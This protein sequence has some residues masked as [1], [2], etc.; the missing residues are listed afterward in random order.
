MD[1]REDPVNRPAIAPAVV[2]TLVDSLAPRLRRRLELDPRLAESWSWTFTDGVWTVQADSATEVSLHADGVVSSKDQIRC[3]CLLA[4][5]CL[6]L[7][8]V[9]LAL[10]VQEV[11]PQVTVLDEGERVAPDDQVQLTPAQAEAVD[12]AVRVGAAMLRSGAAAFGLV[13]EAELLRTAHSCRIVGLH[14]LAAGLVRVVQRGRE[15]RDQRPEFR[16]EALAA[17]LHEVLSTALRLQRGPATVQLV[18]TARRAYRPAGSLQVAGIFTEAIVSAAGYA[19]VVT[20]LCDSTGRIWSIAD[21]APG[22]ADRCQVAY[23]SSVGVG[24]LRLSHAALSRAG[25]RLQGMTASADR[26]LGAGRDVRAVATGG[27]IWSDPPLAALWDE[28]LPRQ[29]DRV[30]ASFDLDVTERGAG[31]DLVYLAGAVVGV[32]GAALIVDTPAGQMECLPP[33]DHAELAY[34]ENLRLLGSGP[35]LKVRFVGR[36]RTGT[37]RS[38][39]ILALGADES[40][41]GLPLPDEWKS[42]VNLGLDRLQR[43]QVRGATGRPVV[44]RK[45]QAATP[46]TDPLD[47]VRRR[48]LQVVMGG[49][50]AVCQPVWTAIEADERALER[51][52]LRTAAALQRAM[53][54]AVARGPVASGATDPLA[55]GWTALREY[56][57]HASARLERPRWS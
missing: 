53:R 2:A 33:S 37:P 10:P 23:G 36:V 5:K 43:V 34:V 7:V 29:L 12:A 18:G 27:A 46:L 49:A 14:R 45:A 30:W 52:Q 32:A 51:A 42:R 48:L 41:S 16:L 22:E 40:E 19:G 57:R 4:P 13:I 8:A 35:G 20:Y 17:D 50:G 56:E 9:V 24:E 6:H 54:A 25:L 44:L 38:V 3:S 39:R 47:V 31:S 28:P 21:V 15:Y 55:R 26:R 1:T 11:A